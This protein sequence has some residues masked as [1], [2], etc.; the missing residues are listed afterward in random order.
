MTPTQLPTWTHPVAEAVDDAPLPPPA[1]VK[2]SIPPFHLHGERNCGDHVHDP[3][4][5]SYFVRYLALHGR[6]LSSSWTMSCTNCHARTTLN[7]L[8][9]LP[10]GDL[11]CRGCLLVKVL[12]VKLSI[13]R[14]RDKLHDVRMQL[15]DNHNAL[16]YPPS[17]QPLNARDKRMLLRRDAQ[18][19]QSMARLA[20][21][22][23]CGT[24][25]QLGRFLACMG[26][27]ASRELWLA[28]RWMADDPKA[29][30]ACAWPDCGAYLPV[31]CRYVVPGEAGRRWYCVTCQGNSMDCARTWPAAPNVFPYLPRGQ[32][33]LT[34][35]R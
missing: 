4:S 15:V 20:G 8:H 1:E 9:D 21:F 23:C 2:D 28:M 17:E 30:R 14:N 7:R 19:R 11:I 3:N 12:T 22:T 10:C 26:A 31:C 35:C 27:T 6:D 16:F 33:A 5:P 29:H 25:M 24:N 34:P 13:E 32:P 18:L